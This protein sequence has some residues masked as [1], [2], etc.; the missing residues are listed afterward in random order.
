[1]NELLRKI[2]F[3][4]AQASEYARRVDSL[5]YFVIIT[6]MIAATGVFATALLFYVRYKRRAENEPTPRVEPRA[7]HE[8]FF[9]G[10]P[11]AF[12]LLWFAIGYP[13]FVDLSRPPQGAMDVYVQG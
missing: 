4:P 9:I 13:L 3:L 10:V 2:L 11:L 5:H 7:I 6:T 12:F 1:M 8:V